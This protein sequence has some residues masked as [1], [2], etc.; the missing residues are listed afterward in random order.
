MEKTDATH[1]S[2]NCK[3]LHSYDGH[4]GANLEQILQVQHCDC[5][6]EDQHLITDVQV[7][8]CEPVPVALAFRCDVY[9]LKKITCCTNIDSG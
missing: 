7:W 2:K 8:D 9:K 6:K 1:W 3:F 5:S 4:D